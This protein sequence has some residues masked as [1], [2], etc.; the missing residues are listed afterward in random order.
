[1]CPLVAYAQHYSLDSPGV[2]E[3]AVAGTARGARC[4]IEAGALR[5]G[6]GQAKYDFLLAYKEA[7]L[8]SRFPEVNFRPGGERRWRCFLATFSST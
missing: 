7:I 4:D 2:Q 3:I 1:M 5:G 8:I 6:G